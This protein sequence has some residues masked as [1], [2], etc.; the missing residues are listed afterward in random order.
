VKGVLGFS[1]S[2]AGHI[3][4]DPICVHLIAESMV[5]WLNFLTTDGEAGGLANIDN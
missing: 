4:V 1:H 3:F 2:K 5:F